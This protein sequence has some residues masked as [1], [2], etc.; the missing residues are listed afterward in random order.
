MSHFQD[1]GHGVTSRRKLLPPA[2]CTQCIYK[3]P[4]QQCHQLLIYIH[5]CF[6]EAYENKITLWLDW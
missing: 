6:L 3:T 4:M 1:G 5:A 2:E